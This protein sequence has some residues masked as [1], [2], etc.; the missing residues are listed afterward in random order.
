[1]LSAVDTKL[2]VFRDY[3][4]LRKLAKEDRYKAQYCIDLIWS[5]YIIRFNSHLEFDGNV[6]MDEENFKKVAIRLDRFA[7]RCVSKLYHRESIVI[8]LKE[9]SYLP[10]D[11]CEYISDKIDGAFEQIK[12]NYIIYRLSAYEKVLGDLSKKIGD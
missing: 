10:Q 2:Q 6:P 12:L 9:E 7:D 1:M 11:L 5:S 4:P 8:E 3:Q